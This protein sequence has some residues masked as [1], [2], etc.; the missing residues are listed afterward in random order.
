MQSCSVLNRPSNDRGSIAEWLPSLFFNVRDKRSDHSLDGL[1][2]TFSLAIALPVR[3]TFGGIFA[4]DFCGVAIGNRFT[5]SFQRTFLI[6]FENKPLV[7]QKCK[8]AEDC[9]LG[10][11]AV[12]NAFVREKVSE[13]CL[14]FSVAKNDKGKAIAKE[15]VI[16]GQSWD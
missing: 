3:V 11:T 1:D 16:H 6:T 8:I 7:T 2:R 15:P 12:R 14:A 10:K 13:D 4:R 9:T 5:E